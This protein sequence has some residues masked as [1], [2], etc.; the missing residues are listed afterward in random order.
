MSETAV[1]ANQFIYMLTFCRL[2]PHVLTITKERNVWCQL[3]K[4][5][6]ESRDNIGPSTDSVSTIVSHYFSLTVMKNP[7]LDS[8]YLPRRKI[9]QL[10]IEEIVEPFGLMGAAGHSMIA[11]AINF[12]LV[13]E[14][15]QRQLEL[16]VYYLPLVKKL[17]DIGAD[18]CRALLCQTMSQHAV[19]SAE[20]VSVLPV[21]TRSRDD[22]FII[23]VLF[24]I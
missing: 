24:R 11:N 4:L 18:R 2:I 1:P 14:S 13:S 15:P 16:L 9:P 21:R 7:L 10:E 3:L 6:Y 23:K 20:S 19:T 5:F 22:L 17:S 12:M 8:V